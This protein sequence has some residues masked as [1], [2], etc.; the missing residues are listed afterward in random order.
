VG[1][2]RSNR[3]LKVMKQGIPDPALDQYIAYSL[4]QTGFLVTVNTSSVFSGE[5]PKEE[6]RG[7]RSKHNKRYN[8]TG[9][10]SDKLQLIHGHCTQ[11]VE[12][13]QLVRRSP[14]V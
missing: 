6:K 8:S 5:T 10:L 7:C 1:Q 2:V 3:G 13:T 4:A 14:G 11:V 12:Y 9:L